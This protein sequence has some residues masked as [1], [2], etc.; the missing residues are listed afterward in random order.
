MKPRTI[1]FILCVVGAAVAAGAEPPQS[2]PPFMRHL[3]PPEL[4]MRHQH[5]IGLVDE[6]RE[7]I[8]AAIGETQA[9]VVEIQWQLQDVERKLEDL[10]SA[11]PIDEGAALEE[12]G[13]A[14]DL[15]ERVK[16]AHL[17][18][19]IRIRNQLTRPQRTRLDALRSKT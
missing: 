9:A 1:A 2:P 15:E 4:V 17:R 8:T 11:E 16:L 10:F 12:V 18:L 7:V 14:L 5:D 3:Y 19:L 6:Q 13:R